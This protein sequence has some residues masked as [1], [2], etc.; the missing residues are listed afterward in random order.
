M[1]FSPTKKARDDLAYIKAYGA[2][3]YW[4]DVQ[5]YKEITGK[6]WAYEVSARYENNPDYGEEEFHREV[7]LPMLEEAQDRRFFHE[8]KE[9]YKE[10]K[11]LL[12]TS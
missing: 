7:I 10:L 1:S 12:K 4:K 9:R 6:D 11:E 5:R 3:Q 2:K 8:K